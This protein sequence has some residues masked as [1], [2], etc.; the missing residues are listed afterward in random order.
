MKL[1]DLPAIRRRAERDESKFR[2]NSERLTG[3]AAE[4]MLGYHPSVRPDHSGK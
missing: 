4:E 3:F 1:S 2:H